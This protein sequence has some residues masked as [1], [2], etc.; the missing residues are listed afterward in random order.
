[1]SD[2]NKE[3]SLSTRMHWE[4]RHKGVM[5]YSHNYVLKS[6]GTVKV[7]ARHSA[8]QPYMCAHHYNHIQWDSESFSSR[9]YSIPE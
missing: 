1:M 5:G 9:V 8:Y 6:S 2:V 3:L 7:E 4:Y